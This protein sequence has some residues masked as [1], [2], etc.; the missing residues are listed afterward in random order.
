MPL[1]KVIK[2]KKSFTIICKKKF[3][4]KKKK[5]AK[6]VKVGLILELAKNSFSKSV[7]PILCK[8]ETA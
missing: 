6:K 4:T 5:S 1:V 2:H 3:L 8:T 7:L